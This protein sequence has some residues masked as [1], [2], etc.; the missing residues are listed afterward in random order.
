M[1]VEMKILK[2]WAKQKESPQIELAFKAR[3]S[4]GTVSKLFNGQAPKKEK[5]REKIAFALNVEES[6][7]FPLEPEDLAS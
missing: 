5:T 4:T 6:E 1:K 3:V 2:N 7:L